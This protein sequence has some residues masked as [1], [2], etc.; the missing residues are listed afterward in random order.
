MKRNREGFTLLEVMLVVTI[1]SLLTMIAMPYI[2]VA[3]SRAQ[4]AA[5]AAH[6]SLVAAQQRA[7]LKQH[8]VVVDFDTDD[9]L[10]RF[11]DDTNRNGVQDAGETSWAHALE[12]TLQFGRGLAPAGPPGAGAITFA[13][14]AGG[15]PRLTFHRS[16]S[17]SS[18][19]GF[20]VSTPRAA[21]SSSHIDDAF[22][23]TVT[24]ATGRVRLHRAGRAGWQEAF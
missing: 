19:G 15:D 20:Y 24:R 11:F 8:D 13:T 21:A 1:G 5:R 23:I 2:D 16:G 10:L 17:A 7:V 9:A 12:E 22:A 6:M 4:S 18:A 14:G 3:G